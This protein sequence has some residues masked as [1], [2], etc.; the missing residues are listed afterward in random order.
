MLE[1][2]ADREAF[3]LTRSEQE[4]LRQLEKAVPDLDTECMERA[5][6]TVQLAFAADASLPVAVRAKI[7]ASGVHYVSNT[8]RE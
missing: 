6:A 4:E 7:R 5:A 8:S 3:G 1:L 2:L